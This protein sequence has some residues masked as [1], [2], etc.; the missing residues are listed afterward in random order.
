MNKISNIPG[1]GATFILASTHIYKQRK[2]RC[3][4]VLLER[5]SSEYPLSKEQEAIAGELF[6]F[7]RL[8]R[9]SA[10]IRPGDVCNTLAYVCRGSLRVYAHDRQGN[11]YVIGMSAEGDW[12]YDLESFT[13]QTAS[14]V[15]I[16][17][18]EDCELLI[19]EK[20]DL[21]L[22]SN[23]VPTFDR[24]LEQTLEENL[25]L[26]QDLMRSRLSLSAEGRLLGFMNA[27]PNA[28]YRF[29]QTLIASYLGITPETLSRVLKKVVTRKSRPAFTV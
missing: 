5:I 18:L 13:R 23:V 29:S 7:G 12:I 1:A 20:A 26:N 4:K 8:K 17:A 28:I 15:C 27:Q 14:Q 16:E 6:K 3:L 10:L 2:D 22:L 11:D 21:A 25:I 9:K 19:I 24:F